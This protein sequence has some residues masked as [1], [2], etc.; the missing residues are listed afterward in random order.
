MSRRRAEERAGG[1]A[2]KQHLYLLFDDWTE[3]YSVRQ[4][5]LSS[6]DAASD[7]ARGWQIDATAC[8]GDHSLPPAIFRFEAQRGLPAHL[9]AA[10]D[11]KIVATQPLSPASAVAAPLLLES[12]VP[13]FDVRHRS[14]LF[15]PR[16]V[17]DR[18]D[19]I[20]IPAGRRL[21]ALAAGTFDL[22]HPPPSQ[23]PRPPVHGE[24]GRV[25]SWRQLSA[26]PFEREHV[27]SYAVH[28][29]GTTI[30]VSVE[31]SASAPA[32]FAFDTAEHWLRGGA[33]G[34]WQWHGQWALPFAGRAHFDAELDAWV[35]FS[36]DPD[37]V[38]HVCCCDAAPA[39]PDDAGGEGR[40]PA[41]KLNKEKLFS[42][43]PA[44]RHLGA[45]LVYMGGRSEF[46]LVECVFIED[47]RHGDLDLEDGDDCAD[48]DMSDGDLDEDDGSSGDERGDGE[49]EDEQDPSRLRRYL[50]RLTT[51]NLK[52]DKN[53]DL[54]TGCSCRVRYYRVPH[55]SSEAVLSNPVAFWM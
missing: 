7:D 52:Y 49:Q 53:G 42:E 45:T 35:G 48:E 54:T 5:D 9:A 3:G 23:P 18:A 34:W 36:R 14:C 32:T 43:E 25:W 17:P 16:L 55:E 1:P 39:I 38:G 50:F 21:F 4:V 6:D 20:Y 12:H 27:A 41:R 33:G 11:S 37:C 10:F 8:D 31:E 44:E 13:I 40:C 2:A 30:F 22:L 26:P 24:E 29:N 46:C 47:E 15:G 19:P 51:F 28:P